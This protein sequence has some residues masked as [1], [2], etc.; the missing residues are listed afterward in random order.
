MVHQRPHDASDAGRRDRPDRHA[1][2]RRCSDGPHPAPSARRLARAAPAR[3]RRQRQRSAWT[4][5]RRTARLLE[6]QAACEREGRSR[7]W[8]AL[9]QGRPRPPD[10]AL[11]NPAKMP[12]LD[13]L[14]PVIQEVRAWDLASTVKGDWT[15][16]VKLARCRPEHQS[17]LY[18]VTDVVRFRGPPELVRATVRRVA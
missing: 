11:F 17:D 8:A 4:P 9:Y 7:D 18:V 6:I 13:I 2:S 15:C 16:G 5:D 14:P 1:V 10:G 12:V 3:H